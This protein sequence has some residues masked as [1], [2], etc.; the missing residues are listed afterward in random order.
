MTCRTSK[1][2][3]LLAALF[4]FSLLLLA[5]SSAS[6][7][8]V[9]YYDFNTP[10]ANPSQYTYA[11]TPGSATNPLFCLNDGTRHQ[12]QARPFSSTPTPPPSIPIPSHNPAQP[13]SYYATQ[14]TPDAGGQDEQ[15]LVLRAPE[16]RQRIHHLVRLQAHPRQQRR[17]PRLK[18]HHRRRPR[19]RHPELPKG[20]Q[21]RST[22]PNAGC[23]GIGGS[24]PHRPRYGGGG[25][26]GYS[27]IDNSLA[28]E[29]DTY[30]QL[31]G[32]P[33]TTTPTTPTTITT[34][35]SRTAAPA[36]P[37]LPTTTPSPVAPERAPPPVSCSGHPHGLRQR[38]RP[39]PRHP[40]PEH[41]RQ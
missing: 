1:K 33:T 35:P 41:H 27:G 26:M 36:C 37:T 32:T 7:Q 39:H 19:L 25:G 34:S 16:R 28:L 40:A 21:R 8:Q 22:I 29:F 17:P 11:C 12:F 6:A 5:A 15:P 20:R 24:R 31:A 4:T 3:P 38:P 9:T 13:G 10:Q 30:S 18:L 23:T 2:N 14:M